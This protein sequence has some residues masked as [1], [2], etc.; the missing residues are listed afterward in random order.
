M[1][2][3]YRSIDK[4][5]ILFGLEAEDVAFVV[6]GIGIGSL[7]FEPYVP[8]VLG[9]AS[10]IML[11]RFK[12]GKPAGYLLHRLYALGFDFPGHA[13]SPKKVKIYGAYA[14]TTIEKHTVY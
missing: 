9:I 8:G 12:R 14:S 4:P 3:C 2:L 11:V 6:L 10:W 5:Q 7:L 1:H 13:P